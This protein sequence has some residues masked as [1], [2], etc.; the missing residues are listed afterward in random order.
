MELPEHLQAMQPVRF[1]FRTNRGTIEAEANVVWKAGARTVW[2]GRS[3]PVEGGVLHG[4]VFTHLTSD[5]LQALRALLRSLAGTGHPRV[6]LPLDAPALCRPQGEGSA[7]LQGWTGDVSRGGLSLRLPHKLP[8]GTVLKIHL[9]TPNTPLRVEGVVV[10]AE[11]PEGGLQRDLIRHGIRI[12]A[13][14]WYTLLSL[15]LLL[16]VTQ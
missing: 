7:P 15:G 1:R 12:T 9:E 11:S 6:R 4:L 10:W 13:I 3:G 8:P 14:E 5:Q 2:D 16:T